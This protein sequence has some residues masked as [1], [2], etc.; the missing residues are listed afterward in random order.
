MK[1]TML[2]WAVAALVLGA[3]ACNKENTQNEPE[4][5]AEKIH[6]TVKAGFDESV[7]KTYLDGMSVKWNDDDEIGIIDALLE[8]TSTNAEKSAAVQKF[9]ISDLSAD[10]ATA[11][12]EGS[13]AP[14][15]EKYYAAYPFDATDFVSA[16][17]GYVRLGFLSAQ[18]ASAPG[19][20][21]KTYNSSLALLKDGALNFKNLGGLLK[22]ELLDDNVKS[23]T[24]KAN[25]NG[26]I[27][28]VYYVT[29]DDSGNIATETLASART[30]MTLSPAAGGTFAPGVY[31]FCLSARTYTGGITLN[32][33]LSD[34]PN[35]TVGTTADVVVARSK[36]TS[37]GK[38][39][40][41]ISSVT[42]VTFPVV[43]PMG[44]DSSNA[45]YNAASNEWV[46]DWSQD[47][48]CDQ[49]TR[50][51]QLWTGHHG[52][53]YS[54]D[55]R[56]AY[57]TWN[58][59][60]AIVATTVKHFIET[61][62]SAANKISVVGVKGVWTGDY[63]EFVLPVQNFDAGTTLSLTM[64]IYTRN[65]P[66]F[67]EVKYLDGGTWK[68]TAQANLPAY[69]GSE[70]TATATWAVP[71][72]GAAQAS[73]TLNTNQTVEM[74]FDNAIAQGEV[75]IRVICVDGSIW[76]TADNTVQTGKT[77]PAPATTNG[78]ANA[79]FY[80]WNPGDRDNQAITIDIVNI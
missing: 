2:F 50:T 32:C 7:T 57:M 41:A 55:Q 3:V 73:N 63:F 21:D 71:F 35:K 19:T 25:D 14:G 30:S 67:W 70:V 72:G 75:K 58:W 8:A 65:G 74:T 15:L 17:G 20:F 78:T 44:Y 33:T 60:D 51:S 27:G 10:N 42:P 52:T 59:A 53:L 12:F 37:V 64:P 40:T 49:S 48:A 34:G 62:N 68:T 16:S 5:S 76:S 24:L 80:F 66:T 4:Q 28:G 18:K 6:L 54:K 22:F 39:S 69:T 61:A 1:K 47:A 31:Y 23:V 45:G 36:I 26:T 77:G 46:L 13:I 79:P 38:I 11:T 29:L 9:T 43:F 56:Q